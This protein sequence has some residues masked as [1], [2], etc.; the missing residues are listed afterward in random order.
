MTLT[1]TDSCGYTDTV[2]V[3]NALTVVKPELSVGKAYE[4]SRVAGTVVTFTL[5]VVNAGDGQATN[6][7]LSDTVPA[8]VQFGGSDGTLADGDVTWNF[9][10]IGPDGGEATGWFSG[11]LPCTG[12]VTNDAYGVVS[13]DQ[14]ATAAGAPVDFAILAPALKPSFDQSTLSPKL[15]ET[16]HFASTS[17]TD[18]PAIVGWGWDFGDQKA[19]SGKTV[20]H[21]YT[22]PGTYTVTL[23]I[24]DTCGYTGTVAVPD[25]VTISEYRVYLPIV[26]RN[27]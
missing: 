3:E 4:G 25:A 24:T 15:D 11:T 12:T 16:V 13:S 5:T 26:V 9:A 10:S 2:T 8:G 18:G 6:A 19:G 20:S 23:T 1:I 27:P 21:A 7:V 22:D 14:G 17:T